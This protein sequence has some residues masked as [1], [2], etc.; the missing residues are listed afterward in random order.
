MREAASDALAIMAKTSDITRGHMFPALL[1]IL[2][3]P[4]SESLPLIAKGR[5]DSISSV[6]RF[7]V[8]G[9][10][11]SVR[12]HFHRTQQGNR[13]LSSYIVSA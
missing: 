6:P 9:S 2:E 12:I 11:L 8:L 4:S 7:I 10:Y 13:T 1:H 5:L 3:N